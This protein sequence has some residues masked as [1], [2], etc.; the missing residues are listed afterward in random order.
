MRHP[1]NPRLFAEESLGL[2]L[3]AFANGIERH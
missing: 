1:L 2:Y 3:D